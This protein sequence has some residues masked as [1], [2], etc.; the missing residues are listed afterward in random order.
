MAYIDYHKAFDSVP[1]S[2]LVRVFEIYKIDSLV[3][4]SLQHLM[5]KWTTTLRVTVK[6]IRSLATRSASDEEYIKGIVLA[7]Y[8]SVLH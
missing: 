2:W 4:N 7:R 8:G 1:H 5:K 6:T 3:I